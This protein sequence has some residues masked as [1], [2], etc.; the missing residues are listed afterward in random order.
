MRI[1]KCVVVAA[2]VLLASGVRAQS[3]TTSFNMNDVAQFMDGQYLFHDTLASENQGTFLRFGPIP[4]FSLPSVFSV[5]F[6]STQQA[7]MGVWVYK[8]P[9]TVPDVMVDGKER[10]SA[11][12][13][14][15][16]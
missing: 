2:L 15:Y 1:L 14:Q 13:A 3:S 7:I 11:T 8:G 9:T 12:L 16:N 4:L 5:S 10:A 6:D